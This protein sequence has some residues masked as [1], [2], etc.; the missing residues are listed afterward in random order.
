MPSEP[1]VLRPGTSLSRPCLNHP[2]LFL[3]FPALSVFLSGVMLRCPL[4]KGMQEKMMAEAMGAMWP[5]AI[6]GELC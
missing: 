5:A 4:D 6:V 1:T 3:V 2:S